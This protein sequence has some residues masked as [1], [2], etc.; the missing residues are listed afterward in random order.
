MKNLRFLTIAFVLASLSLL[1]S[2]KKEGCTD[3]DGINYSA[4]AKKDDGSCKY[5]GTVQ[6]WYGQAT[7][8]ALVASGSTSLMLQLGNNITIIADS[9]S[10]Y[11]FSRATN[12]T[13]TSSLS[14][15][16]SAGSSRI[17]L[18][19][20]FPRADALGGV[21]GIAWISNLNNG[22]AP[23]VRA[24]SHFYNSDNGFVYNSECSASLT[25]TNCI[26]QLRIK[27]ITGNISSGR[28][29]VYGL[30]AS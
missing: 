5:E 4:D 29:T 6:F 24:Q 23:A 18:T 12:D 14:I 25:V 21:N 13:D 7:A 3:A 20:T 2:C 9:P 27:F 19:N 17:E 30:K 16:N 28:V 22:A 1:S 26:T 15:I 11:T 8:D 10:N